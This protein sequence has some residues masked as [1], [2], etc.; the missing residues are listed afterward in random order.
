[1]KGRCCTACCALTSSG[2][3]SCRVLEDEKVSLNEVGNLE[4]ENAMSGIS[5]EVRNF[6]LPGRL[7]LKVKHIPL[8]LG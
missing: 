4:D 6:C 7:H 2:I 3:G 1:M 8:R 5:R